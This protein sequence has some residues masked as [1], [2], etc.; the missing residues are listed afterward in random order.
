MEKLMFICISNYACV[1]RNQYFFLLDQL[2]ESDLGIRHLF[3]M[4]HVS[5][6][7]KRSRFSETS[8]LSNLWILTISLSPWSALHSQIFLNRLL[9]VSNSF[10]CLHYAIGGLNSLFVSCPRNFSCLFHIVSISFYID[11][12]FFL[13]LFVV[14][15]F[16]VWY[17]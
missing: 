11:P 9:T 3:L 6:G 8:R 15:I 16:S 10:S 12:F 2:K 17:R 7:F 4:W 13:K 14:N 1:F 5:S